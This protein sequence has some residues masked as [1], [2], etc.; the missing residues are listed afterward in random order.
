MFCSVF[1]GL[2]VGLLA[3]KQV[4]CKMGFLVD[5]DAF[6]YSVACW[7]GIALS[8]YA[9]WVE[10]QKHRNPLYVAACDLG[11]NMKCSRVLTSESVSAVF[12]HAD[13]PT[14]PRP[15]AIYNWGWDVFLGGVWFVR[16]ACLR[17]SHRMRFHAPTSYHHWRS[18]DF[19]LRGPE[20]RG[21][22]GA[23]FETPKASS[24][25]GD[26]EGVPPSPAD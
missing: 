6:S 5:D 23:E 25:E 7:C 26:G 16:R 19:V 12:F 14:I 10:I 3:F 11:D 4:V 22:V 20:N 15:R 24:G 1:V 9:L 21:A 17:G 18:Q 8:V 13:N 2:L